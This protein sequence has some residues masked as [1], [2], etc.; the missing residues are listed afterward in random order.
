MPPPPL[1]Y[2]AGPRGQRGTLSLMMSILSLEWFWFVPSSSLC[3]WRSLL[4]NS[5]A[6]TA[7][8]AQN[9]NPRLPHETSRQR[10]PPY[11]S[12]GPVPRPYLRPNPKSAKKRATKPTLPELRPSPAPPASAQSEVG[13]HRRQ[14]NAADPRHRP[15]LASVQSEDWIALCSNVLYYL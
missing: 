7:C 2:I 13:P 14:L 9:K 12:F 1:L 10:S 3:C 6:P 15:A 4:P 5:L 11:L 8:L